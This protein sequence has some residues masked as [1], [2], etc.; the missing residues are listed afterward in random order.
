MLPIGGT[1][2]N[3]KNSDKQQRKK[4]F[5]NNSSFSCYKITLGYSAHCR[6]AKE[7]DKL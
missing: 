1:T 7:K 2:P 6:N 5:F 3:S 4:E